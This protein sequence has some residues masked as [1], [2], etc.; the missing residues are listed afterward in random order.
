M[1][2]S[3]EINGKDM[4][5]AMNMIQFTETKQKHF[6]NPLYCRLQKDLMPEKET[7]IKTKVLRSPILSMGSV[8][9]KRDNGVL[10]SPSS[11]TQ[12]QKN[13]KKNLL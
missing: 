9:G 10:G 5:E 1:T 4:Q 8:S 11:P 6:G 3:D 12:N 7:V 13:K 2:S